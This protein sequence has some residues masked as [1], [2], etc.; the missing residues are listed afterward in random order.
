MTSSGSRSAWRRPRAASATRRDGGSLHGGGYHNAPHGRG[1]EALPAVSRRPQ[2]GQG[3]SRAGDAPHDAARARLERRSAGALGAVGRARRAS[4]LLVLAVVWGAARVSLVR[5]RRGRGE[6]AA[7]A[8]GEGAA[9]E[10]RPLRSSPSR[11]RVLVIGTDGG[12]APG[13]RRRATART[14]CCS[15]HLDPETHRISY[16][17]IP[18]DLRVEIPGYGTSKINAASQI[19]GPALTI[20]TVKALIGLPIDHVVVV[21]FDGFKELIDAIGGIE[22]NV[23]KPILSNTFDCPYKPKRC[24]DWE[25][26][27]FEKGAQHMD[28]RRALVYS[29]IRTNQ[30]DPSDTDITRGN[31]QQIVADAVGDEI[32]SFGTFLR[33][34]FMGGE[35]AAPL[36]TDLSAW[37]LAQ[38]GWVRFRSSRLAALPPRR[39]AELARRR[40]RPPRLGGQR[41]GDLDVA[42]PVGAPRRPRRGRS[43]APA[44]RGASSPSRTPASASSPSTSFSAGLSFGFSLGRGRLALLRLR[45]SRAVV[46][47]VEPGALE[48]HRDRE[49]QLLDGAGAARRARLGGRIATSSGRARTCGRSGSGTRRS[50]QWAG[51]LAPYGRKTGPDRA[52]AR[53]ARGSTARSRRPRAR[54]AGLAGVAPADG[55]SRAAM[56]ADAPTS[57]P[58]RNVRVPRRRSPPS[59]VG[60]YDHPRDARLHD[61][62]SDARRRRP[63]CRSRSRRAATWTPRSGSGRAGRRRTW[64]R[65]PRRSVSARASS[66]ETG[67]DDAGALAR[68]EA[69]GATGSRSWGRWPGATGRSARSCP[70]PASARWRRIAEPRASSQREDLDPPGSPCDHLHVSGYALMADPRATRGA[71]RGRDR[72]HARRP[73]SASTCRRGARFATAARRRSATRFARS[74]P[75]S[76]SPTRT[77]SASSAG[78]SSTP[79]GSS[80]AGRAAARSTAT[81]A[82]RCTVDGGRLDRG[83]RRARGR[84]DRRRAR[85]RARGRRALRPA[86]G[87]DADSVRRRERAHRGLGRGPRR[88]RRRR[89]GRRPRDDDRR[90][91]VSGSA[92][93]RGG[94]RH[95]ERCAGGG[96]DPRDH[97]CAS[98]AGSAWGSREAELARF[99]STARKLGPR[100]LAAC[101]VAG[102]I[103]ATTVGGVLTVARTVGI[104]VLG[105]GGI[106]GVHRGY[107]SPPDVSAD[108]VA[109]V[110]APVLV[111]S[112][113]AKS[114]LDIPATME[115]L[116]TL[117]IPVLGY[118]TDTLPLFYTAG[119]RTARDA[120]RRRRRHGSADRRGP[121]EPRRLRPPSREPSARE[122]R[123]RRP[124]R[125]GGR[126]RPP[127]AA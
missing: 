55:G 120:A 3:P 65:G 86:A 7:P 26:W 2:E 47:R 62:R 82:R 80:S 72:A 27:R 92:R 56:A 51:R 66:A 93:S 108:L 43:T 29:R 84:L 37:E 126:R 67:A 63:A 102:D 32:A 52:R 20:A 50:A 83:R 59:T 16:L 33:L 11:R 111:V 9:R 44:A 61:R 88:A 40:V 101:A 38:L 113:G 57:P 36:A 1:N 100:D 98:T 97:R 15:L 95:G 17:S 42:R 105:T 54:A 121:L 49:E 39:R 4:A 5:E 75:T 77:K 74:R 118:R 114:L 45:L 8:Q 89:R 81:S 104:R 23:P 53:G 64:P 58:R 123:G 96:R 68:D 99:D 34:P 107:P 106:G 6:R 109:L 24:A 112:S 116:E 46:G 60:S 76:C 117:G 91:R 69:R 115:H 122:H 125:G 19:G 41:R 119:R 71:S 25:G 94:D 70:R 21:D 127:R 22:V 18:R 31:R 30:L 85:P 28:G 73:R 14:R 103:G 48:V 79:F 90:A 124:D 110:T 13:A 78:R 87:R 35:L 10:A 12:R